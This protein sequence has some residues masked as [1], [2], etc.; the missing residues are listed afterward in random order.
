M[1]MKK[2]KEVKQGKNE[3]QT[4]TSRVND[5]LVELDL[6]EDEALQEDI[7]GG[8]NGIGCSCSQDKN[9]D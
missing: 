2:E 5:F 3:L 4:I 6:T 9:L 1:K 8:N 7:G